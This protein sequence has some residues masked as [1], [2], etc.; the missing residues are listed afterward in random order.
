MYAWGSTPYAHPHGMLQSQPQYA[1]HHGGYYAPHPGAPQQIHPPYMHPIIHPQFMPHPQPGQPYASPPGQQSYPT[2]TGISHQGQ[3]FPHPYLNHH[4]HQVHH[5]MQQKQQNQHL[6]QTVMETQ[7]DGPSPSPTGPDDETNPTQNASTKATTNSNQPG[8]N[9]AP[10]NQTVILG[11]EVTV[12]A[13]GGSQDVNWDK[14]SQEEICQESELEGDIY[15]YALQLLC[16]PRKKATAPAPGK[17]TVDQEIVPGETLLHPYFATRAKAP[18]PLSYKITPVGTHTIGGLHDQVYAQYTPSCH[19]RRPISRGM[20]ST[21]DNTHICLKLYCECFAYG[22]M[23][24]D[25]CACSSGCFNNTEHSVERAQA[26]GAILQ[27]DPNG[28]RRDM[29]WMTDLQRS[30]RSEYLLPKEKKVMPLIKTLDH[31]AITDD[32][33]RIAKVSSCADTLIL[34]SS[35]L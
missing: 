35:L 24:T 32:S 4:D 31:E 26:V 8:E 12:M 29:D 15:S 14:Q 13:N 28:F 20:K 6:P 11:E 1:P 33:L 34:N 30:S 7:D 3:L 23:C 18:D 2:T 16:T 17:G 10:Q 9:D 21:A 27:D 5:Q 25:R 22:A 19:C